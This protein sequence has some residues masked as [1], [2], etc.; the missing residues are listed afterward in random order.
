MQRH[1]TQALALEPVPAL[2]SVPVQQR[3]AVW[4]Q[5]GQRAQGQKA[6]A[7]ARARRQGARQD[8]MA[9]AV[10]VVGSGQGW[11][12]GAESAC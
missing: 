7:Q 11:W 8:S 9:A 5:G 6:R 10:A 3:Q 4:G 12:L 1:S 2:E